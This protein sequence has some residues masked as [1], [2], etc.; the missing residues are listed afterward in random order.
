MKTLHLCHW[1]D[2]SHFQQHCQWIGAADALVVY[3]QLNA[4]EIEFI[5]THMGTIERPWYRVMDNTLSDADDH[6]Q[7]PEM[8]SPQQW[9]ALIS[10]HHNTWAWK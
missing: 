10:E 1:H 6:H 2:K 3:G 7:G 5:R 4:L 8:I 9:V